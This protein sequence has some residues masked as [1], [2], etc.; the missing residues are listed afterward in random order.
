MDHKMA[1]LASVSDI[2]HTRENPTVT[3]GFKNLIIEQFQQQDQLN[4]TY[5]GT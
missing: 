4:R 3:D 1:G 2:D 5:D